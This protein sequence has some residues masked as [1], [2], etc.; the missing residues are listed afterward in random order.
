[1]I[2][3]GKLQGG[4]LV[5]CAVAL[6]LVCFVGG[7]AAAAYLGQLDQATAAAVTG[8][9]LRQSEDVRRSRTE[10]LT[11]AR[12]A[13][14]RPVFTAS[15]F[16][17]RPVQRAYRQLPASLAPVS[18]ARAIDQAIVNN[19]E[20]AA[21]A[22]GRAPG[23]VLGQ[24]EAAAVAGIAGTGAAGAPGAA[25]GAEGAAAAEPA[26]EAPP[27]PPPATRSIAPPPPPSGRLYVIQLAS[28]LREDVAMEYVAEMQRRQIAIAI[29]TETDASGREWRHIRVGPFT[30]A[31]A[32]E[33][34]LLELRRREGLTGTVT[35]EPV[36][37][38]RRA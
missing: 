7:F 29:V 16:A 4:M 24:A 37:Q 12:T 35:T 5:L 28:F 1:M 13:V 17:A 22:A 27:P 6:A 32:A 10:L 33:L 2:L 11:R 25:P 3:I 9:A 26:A 20:Q 23:S 31:A 18:P 21:A 30:S 14:T 8:S 15:R 34:R 38:E 19:T 36:Q